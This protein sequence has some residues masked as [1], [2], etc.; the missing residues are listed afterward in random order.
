[1]EGA[2]DHAVASPDPGGMGSEDGVGIVAAAGAQRFGGT[3]RD[4]LEQVL[5]AEGAAQRGTS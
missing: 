5:D 3:R 2:D 1:M 4:A